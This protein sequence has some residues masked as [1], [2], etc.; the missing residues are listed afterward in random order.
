MANVLS[1]RG[2]VAGRLF[3]LGKTSKEI[4]EA[5][6]LRRSQVHNLL[7]LT[8]EYQDHRRRR[9]KT[10]ALILKLHGEGYDNLE[11]ANATGRPIYNV[12]YQVNRNGTPWG[13]TTKVIPVEEAWAKYES[14]A[15][16]R[17]VADYYQVS[18]GTIRRRFKNRQ[19]R[20]GHE[21]M[22]KFPTMEAW[23]EYNSGGTT[24]ERL[25]KKHGVSVKVVASRFRDHK[26]ALQEIGL[27]DAAIRAIGSSHG[28][29]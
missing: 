22:V 18:R 4:G 19:I 23:S 13:H 25:A 1:R 12:A 10:N 8:P 21:P 7:K 3:E 17:E 6:H 11:I 28:T 9:Q 26:K 27:S 24:L 20:T 16:L 5:L 2:T 15:S 29:H 14:G